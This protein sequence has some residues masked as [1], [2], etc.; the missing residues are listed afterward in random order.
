MKAFVCFVCFVSREDRD[1]RK[2]EED[3]GRS[4][5]HTSELQSRETSSYA[6]FCLKKKKIAL[7]ECP[8]VTR[9]TVGSTKI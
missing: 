8:I 3:A 7:W 2:G 4:E 1:V 6:V 5:D 9:N